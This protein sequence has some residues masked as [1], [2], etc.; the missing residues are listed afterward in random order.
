ML[1]QS[2]FPNPWRE[3]EG[4]EDMDQLTSSPCSLPLR[5]AL[6]GP[7]VLCSWHPTSLPSA[8]STPSCP[9]PC[10]HLSRCAHISPASSSRVWALSQMTARDQCRSVLR[11]S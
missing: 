7:A 5:S 3:S 9:G 8:L 10:P 4:Q 1:T 6:C 11:S 2:Q